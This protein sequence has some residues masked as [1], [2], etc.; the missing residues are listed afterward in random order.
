MSHNPCFETIRV[1]KGVLQNLGAH[2]Q[3]LDR[4]CEALWGRV[5]TIHLDRLTVPATL[6]TDKIYKCRVIYDDNGIVKVEWEPYI[7]RTIHRIRLVETDALDYAYK[8]YDR[9]TL[10]QYY[11]Q[12]GDADDVLL[13]KDGLLTDTSY[14]N[15]AF[16]DGHYWYTP[17]SPILPGTQRATLLTNGH[18]RATLLRTRDLERFSH[19]RLV[20]AMMPWGI[21]PTLP[22][23]A[24][25]F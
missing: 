13:V 16:F 21:G 4:T 5:G 14:A 3:R 11:R 6:L 2:Q 15:I 18:L 22:I 8:Y 7:L 12:R 25:V 19:L 23:S 17:A 24:I 1:A 10:E 9:T 20:N